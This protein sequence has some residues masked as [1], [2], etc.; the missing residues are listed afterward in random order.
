[1]PPSVIQRARTIL[2]RLEG[3]NPDVELP[4]P[5]VRPRRKLRVAPADDSQLS[6]L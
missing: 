1:L 4:A 5:E 3:E 6:L 2:G